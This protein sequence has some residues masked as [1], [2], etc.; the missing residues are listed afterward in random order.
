MFGPLAVPSLPKSIER[1]AYKEKR[2]KKND[3]ARSRIMLRIR[4]LHNR[5]FREASHVRALP[6][7]VSCFELHPLN[8]VLQA[9]ETRVRIRGDLMSGE[10]SRASL[11]TAISSFLTYKRA[12][13]NE[14]TARV[15]LQIERK[16]IAP[17]K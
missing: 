14:R 8:Q 17:I 9:T 7:R 13:L 6:A 12:R 5:W 2:E 10:S 11:S 15:R 1:N 3:Y 16:K 4:S